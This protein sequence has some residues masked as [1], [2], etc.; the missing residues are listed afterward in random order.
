MQ[1]MVSVIMITYNHEKYIEEAVNGVLMQKT[2]FDYEL[3]VANDQS[4][5]QTDSVI[6]RILSEHP[7][8][9]RVH[10]IEREKNIGM[11]EN[12][13][14]AARKSRGKYIALCE[15]D[16]YWIDPL[17]LQ[18]Q[19]DFLEQNEEYSMVCH[20]AQII[21][22][23]SGTSYLDFTPA[24]QKQICSTKD[25]FGSNFCTTASI[26]FRKESIS[27]V[28]SPEF[29]VLAGDLFLKLL[30]SLNG[31]LFRMYEVMSVHRITAT[32]ATVNLRK[33]RP[34][35]LRSRIVLFDY[36][37]NISGQKYNKYIRIETLLLESYLDYLNSKSL[38]RTVMLKIYRKVLF[39][40][41]K[42]VFRN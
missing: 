15:G 39:I 8:S 19:V 36:F 11:I 37:N 13:I 21:D 1:V 22:D 27:S 2:D 24:H 4:T 10:Y 30:V 41:R 6:K 14:D 28:Q 40:K 26:V 18:K 38:I 33:N 5:D 9:S 17:K 31:L 3:I 7:L 42:K 16:D 12:F 35:L 23:M 32:G 29:K 34:E 20:D 25:L